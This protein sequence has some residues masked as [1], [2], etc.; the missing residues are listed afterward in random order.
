MGHSST[1]VRILVV[2]DYEPFRRFLCAT[3]QARAEWQVIGEALDG[4]EAIEKAKDL[5][6]DLILLDIGLPILNGIGAADAIS[7][8]FIS[9]NIDANVIAA[10]SNN[11]AGGYVH[12]LHANRDL[13][14]AIEA[15]LRGEALC[16][17]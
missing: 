13:L 5:Q 7:E 14:P 15:V 1:F 2:D 9:Q 10:V 4:S 6:P 17:S 16:Q 3:V 11:G 12:E 8:P